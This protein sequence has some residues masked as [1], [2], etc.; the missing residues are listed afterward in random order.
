[1]AADRRLVLVRSPTREHD[2][3]APY[4]LYQVVSQQGETST[5]VPRRYS[6]FHWL[7]TRLKEDHAD[8]V[9]PPV[10][11][12]HWNNNNQVFVERR[13]RAL[14]RFLNRVALHPKLGHSPHLV[15]F[16]K[17]SAQLMSDMRARS[18]DAKVVTTSESYLNSFFRSTRVGTASD[19]Y[20]Q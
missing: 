17:A 7:W 11:Q 8:C 18:E 9:V 3:L 14:E 4:T 1:M 6:D 19:Y 16:L 13:R 5:S 2:A 15:V 20:C 10:P 12:K